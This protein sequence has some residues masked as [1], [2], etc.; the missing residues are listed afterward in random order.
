VRLTTRRLIVRDVAASD[1][2]PL[3]AIWADPAVTRHLGG[4][5]DPERVRSAVLAAA[6]DPPAL[7]QWT[8]EQD[9][10]VV[11]SCGL[12]RKCVGGRD[13]V[14]LV[15]VLARDAWG[16][17]LAT[18]AA[19]AVRDHASTE[20]GLDRLVALIE[21]AHA[22]SRRVAEKLGFRLEGPVGRPGGRV[23]DLFVR[24]S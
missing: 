13:E 19:A 20:L 22:A 10:R 14:E 11:G 16:R 23:L 21:P 8:V 5:R 9:G 24:E 17:G 7:D 1:A 6:A 18:E 4:P 15:Y 12:L 3:A 2:D